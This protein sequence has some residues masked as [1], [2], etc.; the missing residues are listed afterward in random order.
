MKT[1]RRWIARL[2]DLPNAYRVLDIMDN[3]GSDIECIADME[4]WQ[5]KPKWY[6]TEEEAKDLRKICLH[7]AQY[8]KRSDIANFVMYHMVFRN[9]REGARILKTWI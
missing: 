6:V 3:A 5:I 2:Y 4:M 7:K 8:R 9:V 1:I